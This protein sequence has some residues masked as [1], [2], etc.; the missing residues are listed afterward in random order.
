MPAHRWRIG[1]VGIAGAKAAARH[2]AGYSPSRVVASLEPKARETGAIIAEELSAPFAT[3]LDLHE[4][5]R[6]TVGF[7]AADEFAERMRDLFARPDSVAFGN[8]S[9]VAALARF[10]TA[11]D[12]VV[13]G[14][15]GD[16]VIV[17]HGT[18]IALFVAARAYVDAAELWGKLGLPS[19]VSLE[20]PAYRVAE[21]VT[22]VR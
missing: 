9:A 16:I 20:I 14:S 7:L 12:R 5:D 15:A 4:H 10:A 19:Y 11:V 2:L 17:S 18:V 8:E 3:A 13:S 1:A 21:V 6:R 22:S